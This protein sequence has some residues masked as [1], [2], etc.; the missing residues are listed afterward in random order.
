MSAG[1][2]ERLQDVQRRVRSGNH[3]EVRAL[4]KAWAVPQKAA[5]ESRSVSEMR[6]DVE[7]KIATALAEPVADQDP[8]TVLAE[9]VAA[10][11]ERAKRER[12]ST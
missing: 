12:R 4:A 3:S 7:E 2:R 1:E 9:P 8:A 6:R 5:G 10:Q 11:R